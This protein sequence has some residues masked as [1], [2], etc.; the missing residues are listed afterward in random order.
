[1]SNET[2]SDCISDSYMH[3]F[4]V[5]YDNQLKREQIVLQCFDDA[6]NLGIPEL[7]KLAFDMLVR[8]DD[9]KSRRRIYDLILS[10]NRDRKCTTDSDKTTR[11]CLDWDKIQ[12]LRAHHQNDTSA[13]SQGQESTPVKEHERSTKKQIREKI[14]T[15]EEDIYRDDETLPVQ[16][17]TPYKKVYRRDGTM[18]SPINKSTVKDYPIDVYEVFIKRRSEGTKGDKSP[19]HLWPYLEWKKYWKTVK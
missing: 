5:S 7:E 3:Y 18:R 13:V 9:E 6:V 10:R 14:P 1:M 4:F 16:E 17:E 19:E 2:Y 12:E 15:Q 11:F 8:I